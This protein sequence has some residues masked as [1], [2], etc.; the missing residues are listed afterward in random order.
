MSEELV[1][2]KEH[3]IKNLELYARYNFNTIAPHI[4]GGPYE[5]MKLV[6]I[7]TA[8]EAMK[9]KKDVYTLHKH[10]ERY[11]QDLS[12][13]DLHYLVFKYSDNDEK[14]V[15]IPLEYLQSESLVKV[16]GIKIFI[17]VPDAQMSD[18]V[19][20]QDALISVGISNAVIRSK[21]I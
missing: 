8:Q 17:E 5:K 4:L 11:I 9:H 18:M 20:I 12:V 3:P 6:S 1:N 21:T 13:E 16:E 10:M 19:L 2:I 7:C 14:E 15:C